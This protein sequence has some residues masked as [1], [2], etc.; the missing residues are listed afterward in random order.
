MVLLF[1][2]LALI[3]LL[4]PKRA[5]TVAEKQ[6]ILE[7]RIR[8]ADATWVVAGSANAFPVPT[9]T[10][11]PPLIPRATPGAHNLGTNII[12]TPHTSQGN[13]SAA[14]KAMIDARKK[15]K[16]AVPSAL[17]N[18][19]EKPLPPSTSAVPYM[20]HRLRGHL[21]FW[22]TFTQSTLVL[23]WITTGFDLQWRADMGQP[24]PIHLKNHAS[25]LQHSDFIRTAISELVLSG[26][27]EKVS[28][29]PHCVLPLGIVAKKGGDKYRLIFDAREVNAHLV[30]P[31]FIYEDLG[32]CEN[33]I[34]PNDFLLTFDLS[35]GY[36]HLDIDPAFWKFLGF[37][38]EGHFYVYT[39]LPFGLASACWAFSKVT[40]ELIN[41]WRRSG[42]RVSGYIDD[43]MHAGQ[44]YAVLLQLAQDMILPDFLNCGF[45]VN[46]K[47]SLQFPVQRAEYLGM[48]VDTVRGCFEVPWTKRNKVIALIQA[49]LEH[50]DSCSVHSLEVITGN[51]AS[52]HWAFGPLSRLMTM[53]IYAAMGYAFCT[54]DRVSLT[55]E[56]ISD[57]NFWLDAF[58]VYNGFR[59]IWQPVGFHMTVYTD[60]AGINL[61]CFGGWAGWA[62]VSGAT[63]IAKGTWSEHYA[64]TTH[65]TM[66]ELQAVLNVIQSFNSRAELRGK[67]V[68]LKTDNQGVYFIINKAGSH[69]PEVHALCKLFYWYCIH[70]DISVHASWIPRDLNAFADFHSKHADKGDW[71]LNPAVFSRL[72]NAWGQFDIDLF[73]SYDNYQ[74]IPYYSFSF[75]PNCAGV[76]AFAHS[77]GEKF[78]FCNPPFTLIGKVIAHGQRCGARMCLI[79]P[80]TPSA[81]WWHS[82]VIGTGHLFAPFVR[83][84]TWL[85]RRADLFLSGHVNFQYA[86]RMPRWNSVALLL[87]FSPNH[88][89]P[90]IHV[91]SCG[92]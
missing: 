46:F 58:D 41:K 74:M 89:Q 14:P 28:E 49:V 86:T 17:H 92:V 2:L 78:C 88:T 61:K 84:A 20:R 33:Y 81:V 71:K 10:Q 45:V 34:L 59:H 13:F 15:A 56:A 26:S 8:A 38:W 7:Q 65:S 30:I 21:S 52:M 36:L 77:W 16:T 82:L 79:C 63:Q 73:A 62:L 4:F 51:L 35:K 72:Q 9:A 24:A 55:E 44:S 6:A 85:G 25:T 54:S 1:V 67:R 53:S 5:I 50:P 31:S 68:L 76:D 47:K 27:A 39:S 60:A 37:E 32:S 80:L 57:L 87:D 70:H 22:K 91:P 66:Q 69:A 29:R 48:F 18:Q 90:L 23:K 43:S 40:R 11:Q 64:N 19:G 3:P 12:P 75:T 42:H 83:E